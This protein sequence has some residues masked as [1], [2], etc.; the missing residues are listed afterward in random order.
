[1]P[2]ASSISIDDSLWPLRVVRF[3]G[4]STLQ[5]LEHYLADTSIRLR[6]GERFVSILDVTQ[7]GVPTPE[8]RQRQTLWL[9]ENELLMRELHLGVAFVITSPLI[10]LALSAIFY[11]KPM[12]VPYVVTSR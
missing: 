8:L 10:R 5:Q 11:F 6:R 2:S 9:Q 1:M 7:G 3:V 12:P 4:V